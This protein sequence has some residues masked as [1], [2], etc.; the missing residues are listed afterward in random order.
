MVG[1]FAQHVGQSVT[2]PRACYDCNSALMIRVQ[3]L[4]HIV[5]HSLGVGFMQL[6]VVCEHLCYRCSPEVLQKLPQF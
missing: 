2:L 3:D 1:M 5:G 6:G 4:L